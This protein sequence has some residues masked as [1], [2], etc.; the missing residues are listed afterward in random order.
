M[1][2]HCPDSQQNVGVWVS[3]VLVVNGKVSNHALGNELRFAKF[4]EHGNVLVFWNLSR[5]CQHDTAGKLR[6][7]LI[8]YGFHGVPER[9]PICISGRRMRWQHDFGV[10]KFFLFVVKFCF[11]VVFAEQTFTA[12]ISCTS[13]SGLP[14]TA[15]DNADFEVRT[16]NRHHPQTKRPPSKK[17]LVERSEI[18]FNFARSLGSECRA[19]RGKAGAAKG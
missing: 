1:F 18:V 5:K 10:N 9:G 13:N 6:I 14:L 2:I 3:I 19:L 12:L 17:A 16:R 8:F 11:L 7:P 4:F 15:L